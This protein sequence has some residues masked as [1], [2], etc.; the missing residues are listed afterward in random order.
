MSNKTFSPAQ[1]K[2]MVTQ[3]GKISKVDPES[4]T[5]SRLRAEVGTWGMPM[6]EQV[7]E[8]H[9]PWLSYFATRE[10]AIRAEA[11]AELAKLYPVVPVTTIEQN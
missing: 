9:I 3:F 6:L 4:P 5:I 1:I 10:I 8:A 7:R 2:T 11:A